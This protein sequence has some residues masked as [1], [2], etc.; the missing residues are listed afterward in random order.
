[1]VALALVGCVGA[2]GL[3]LAG[4]NRLSMVVPYGALLRAVNLGGSAV[5][6][7]GDL[8]WGSAATMVLP[9]LA[10]AAVCVAI[11]VVVLETR[12]VRA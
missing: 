2:I 10:L 4:A 9:A 1:M 7:A 12:D 3:T 6:D 5:S 8:T 11:Q